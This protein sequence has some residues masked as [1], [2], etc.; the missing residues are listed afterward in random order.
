MSDNITEFK[1]LG[2]KTD[3]FHQRLRLVREARGYTQAELAKRA[4]LHFGVISHFETSQRLPSFENLR[5]LVEALSC[6]ADYLLGFS[7]G[8]CEDSY[9]RG[10]FDA[11]EAMKT[12]TKPLRLGIRGSEVAE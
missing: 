5:N 12:A 9:R 10:A 11:V 2:V 7:D 4:G 6:T 8:R 1:P 3:H